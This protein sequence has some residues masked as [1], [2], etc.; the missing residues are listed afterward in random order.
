MENFFVRIDLE[1]ILV[2]WEMG[3]GWVLDGDPWVYMWL[4]MVMMM[5]LRSTSLVRS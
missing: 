3:G 4:T 1:V 2:P 5:V